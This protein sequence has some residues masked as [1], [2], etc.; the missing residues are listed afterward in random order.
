M[1]IYPAIVCLVSLSVDEAL[2]FCAYRRRWHFVPTGGTRAV[3]L[4][5]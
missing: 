4:Q 2:A 5:Q 3:K 1:I